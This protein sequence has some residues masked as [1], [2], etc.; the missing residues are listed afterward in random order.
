[1]RGFIGSDNLLRP[2]A[3]DEFLDFRSEKMAKQLNEFLGLG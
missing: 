3:Y 1:V 2:D